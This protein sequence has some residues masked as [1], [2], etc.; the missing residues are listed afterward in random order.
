VCARDIIFFQR[1][2]LALNKTKQSSGGNVASAS[3]ATASGERRASG[4]YSFN[5]FLLECAPS[6]SKQTIMTHQESLPSPSFQG[7]GCS[8]SLSAITLVIILVFL[9][10]S[11]IDRRIV[12][13]SSRR[14]ELTT[15]LGNNR[16]KTGRFLLAT[17]RLADQ[18][19]RAQN[20]KQQFVLSSGFHPVANPHQ[21]YFV[22]I[23][24]AGEHLS[25]LP[26]GHKDNPLS[27]LADSRE[28]YA[29]RETMFF[30]VVPKV[31]DYFVRYVHLLQCL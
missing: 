5:N 12:I 27:W 3:G 2:S 18:H 4:E 20:T 10:S 7:R 1:A 21:P 13:I 15:E 28:P 23:G 26:D 24:A 31:I 11:S 22:T 6:A 25:T 17:S 19:N 14:S 29:R 30:F 16:T 8:T 9:S